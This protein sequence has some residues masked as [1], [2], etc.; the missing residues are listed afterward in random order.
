MRKITDTKERGIS[1]DGKRGHED[2]RLCKTWDRMLVSHTESHSK[3]SGVNVCDNP[4]G[5]YFVSHPK[6][7]PFATNKS[8]LSLCSFTSFSLFFARLPLT[9]DSGRKIHV[10]DSRFTCDHESR[11]MR[12]CRFFQ[13]L[14]ACLPVY[15]VSFPH[16][17]R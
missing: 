11:C 5:W 1:N 10:S 3:S 16:P 9:P 6:S 8:F 13:S 2:P 15:L 7:I 14:S 4:L 17:K 12:L